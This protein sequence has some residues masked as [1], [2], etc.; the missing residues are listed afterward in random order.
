MK[1]HPLRLAV[2][3][4]GQ[5]DTIVVSCPATREAI[6]V[7]CVDAHGVID[8][9]KSEG[10]EKIRALVLTHLHSDH[11]RQ[12]VTFLK[13]CGARLG[14]ECERVVLTPVP[15]RMPPLDNDAESFPRE[16]DTL[17]RWMEENYQR[18]HGVPTDRHLPVEGELASQID[19]VFPY[20]AHMPRAQKRGYNNTSIVLRVQ[21]SGC[22]AL[23]TGDIEAA[24]WELIP[25]RKF[26]VEA[27]VLKFPH[28]GA[29]KDKNGDPADAVQMLNEVGAK[30]VIFSVGSRQKGYNHPDAHVFDAA[31]AAKATILCTQATSRCGLISPSDP[32]KPNAPDKERALTEPHLISHMKSIGQPPILCSSGTPCAGTVIIDLEDKPIILSPNVSVHR[33]QIVETIFAARHQC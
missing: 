7:D 30:V 12:A 20:P 19:F 22:S 31:R 6:V 8:Y 21:G 10:I 1:P 17:V 11:Y 2:L 18:V 24:G 16:F 28:H 15:P 14:V 4:V 5:G 13:N 23:L 9:L 33:K 32:K 3:D 27:D 25:R 26:V 29:W